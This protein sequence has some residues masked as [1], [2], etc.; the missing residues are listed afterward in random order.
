VDFGRDDTGHRPR[1]FFKTQKEADDELKDW[2]KDAKKHGEFFAR[3]TPQERLAVAGVLSEIKA[4]RLTPRQVWEDFKRWRVTSAAFQSKPYDEAVEAFRER[5]LAAGGDERYVH[6][7]CV[8]LLRFAEGQTK[9]PI[10][11]FRAD[12][13]ETWINVQDWGK[14]TKKSNLGRFSSLWKV[15]V[16]KGWASQNSVDKLEPVG[17]IGVDVRVFDNDQCLNLMAATLHNDTHKQAIA[18]LALG[19]FTG[20]RP[21]EIS[22]DHW[23]WKYINLDWG[24]IEVPAE[25]AKTGDQRHFKMQPVALEWLKLARKLKCELPLPNERKLID[26][27]C[28]LAGVQDWIHD[29]LRKTCATHLS[30]LYKNDWSVVRDLGNSIRILLKHYKALGIPEEVSAAFWKLTPER[31]EKHLPVLL[32]ALQAQSSTESETPSD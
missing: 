31:A 11:E 15:A 7:T 21:E 24:T 17:R 9:R 10:H 14:K 22:H 29:G 26:A 28:E 3:M 19:L 25:V 16:D 8:L 6:D 20:M 5:K 32:E 23:G 27:C 1:R 30:N 4:E 2:N 12:E 13:L 18:P